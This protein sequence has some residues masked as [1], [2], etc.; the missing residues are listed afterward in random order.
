MKRVFDPNGVE[1]V[2]SV[3][4]VAERDDQNRVTHCRVRYDDET[5][6]LKEARAGGRTPEFLIIWRAAKDDGLSSILPE[7]AELADLLR[8]AQSEIRTTRDLL[9]TAQRSLEAAQRE[10]DAKTTDLRRLRDERDPEFIARK[11]AEAVASATEALE[12]DVKNYRARLAAAESE[13]AELR[14]SKRKLREALERAKEQR[15]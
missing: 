7:E 8:T 12:E 14:A 2:R 5:I 9:G 1:L 3:L 13:S 15:R 4:Q 11:V 10:I 6:D